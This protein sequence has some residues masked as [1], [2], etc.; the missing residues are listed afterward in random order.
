MQVTKELIDNDIRGME[1]QLEQLKAQAAQ[2]AGALAVLKN[3]REYLD[4]PEPEVV[5]AISDVNKTVQDDVEAMSQKEIS[6]ALTEQEL[7]ELVAGPGASV[8]A[9]EPIK[10]ANAQGKY[11]ERNSN[12]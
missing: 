5:P 8:E 11:E 1:T 4:Q 10:V 6:H 12:G 2:T 7:A 9:I 3:I